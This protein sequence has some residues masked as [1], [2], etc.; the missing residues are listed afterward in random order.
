[1]SNA[2][3]NKYSVV[4]TK[5]GNVVVDGVPRDTVETALRI[6]TRTLYDCVSGDKLARNRYKITHCD[7]DDEKKT[8]IPDELWEQF[9]YVHERYKTI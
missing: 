6:S 8:K 5:T 2:L 9:R 7:A 4:D 3:T 1:M